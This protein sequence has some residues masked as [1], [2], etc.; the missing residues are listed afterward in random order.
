MAN[1]RER[2]QLAARVLP[3]SKQRA[4]AGAVNP[5]S[6]PAPWVQASPLPTGS[7]AGPLMPTGADAAAFTGVG[8][9]L[10]SRS[11]CSRCDVIVCSQYPSNLI[12]SSRALGPVVENTVGVRAESD[13]C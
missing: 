3:P 6:E 4:A 7:G 1:P 10:R 13:C 5:R 2:L 12:W 11:A 8:R 9:R